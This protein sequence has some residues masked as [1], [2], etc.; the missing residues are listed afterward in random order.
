MRVYDT[1]G[2]RSSRLQTAVIVDE[3]AAVDGGIGP[4]PADGIACIA[5]AGDESVA[6]RI[7]LASSAAGSGRGIWNWGHTGN[8]AV[9]NCIVASRDGA[10]IDGC[11][12][13]K[14]QQQHFHGI[15]LLPLIPR[16]SNC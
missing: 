9:T 12:A 7:G 2:S 16:L 8:E 1:G 4:V 13:G 6:P 3:E 11:S 14:Q 15:L 10:I 5:W